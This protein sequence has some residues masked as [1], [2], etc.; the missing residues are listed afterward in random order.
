MRK[1]FE[2]PEM[3]YISEIENTRTSLLLINNHESLSYAKPGMPN[4]V[5][6]GGMHI[7]ASKP[8]PAVRNRTTVRQS[9]HWTIIGRFLQFVDRGKSPVASRITCQQR[10]GCTN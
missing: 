7:E 2:D 4:M 10:E 5:N 8:L 3:P 9:T 1:N 6:V